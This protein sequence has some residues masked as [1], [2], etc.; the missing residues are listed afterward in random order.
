M[1]RK[2]YLHLPAKIWRNKTYL[3]L[4][5]GFHPRFF[6]ESI[7][8]IKRSKCDRDYLLSNGRAERE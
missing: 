8:P 6:G 5:F 3:F 4:F 1:S 2:I 7:C